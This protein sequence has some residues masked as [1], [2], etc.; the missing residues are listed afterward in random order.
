MEHI[1]PPSGRPERDKFSL[2]PTEIHLLISDQTHDPITQLNLALTC[3]RLVHSLAS[4]L[5]RH[6]NIA[7]RFSVATDLDP[8]MVRG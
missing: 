6:R 1:P 3:K 7:K 8:Y 2:L 4:I 5:R